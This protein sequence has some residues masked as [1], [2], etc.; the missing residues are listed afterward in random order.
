MGPT[1]AATQ[2]KFDLL[3][4]SSDLSDVSYT[5]HYL[6]IYITVYHLQGSLIKMYEK[7]SLSRFKPG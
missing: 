2:K 1:Q 7:P 4:S 6:Y 5:Q 3:F